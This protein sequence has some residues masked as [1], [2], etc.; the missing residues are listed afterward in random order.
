MHLSQVSHE[1]GSDLEYS[2]QAARCRHSFAPGPSKHDTWHACPFVSPGGR[3][4]SRDTCEGAASSGGRKCLAF[5]KV[6]STH[7]PCEDEAEREEEGSRRELPPSQGCVTRTRAGRLARNQHSVLSS[8]VLGGHLAGSTVTQSTGHVG[9]CPPAPVTRQ[10]VTV[11]TAWCPRGCWRGWPSCPVRV[12]SLLLQEGP[13]CRP[14]PVTRARP[15]AG[16]PSWHSA[17]SCLLPCGRRLPFL[18]WSRECQNR[19]QAPPQPVWGEGLRTMAWLPPS[20]QGWAGLSFQ[21]P[22]SLLTSFPRRRNLGGRQCAH[23]DSRKGPLRSPAPRQ[24]TRAGPA[25]VPRGPPRGCWTLHRPRF[26]NESCHILPKWQD[27]STFWHPPSPAAAP[28]FKGSGSARTPVS[29][30]PDTLPLGP[31]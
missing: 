20:A 10:L 18:L 4:W 7:H 25:P 19:E 28:Q 23:Q 12:P 14:T 16:Q 6:G 3:S 9:K 31:S 27:H 5:S 11:V 8:L 15:P 26:S 29:S 13:P 24:S 17:W 22:S 2:S 30:C 21:S 1:G